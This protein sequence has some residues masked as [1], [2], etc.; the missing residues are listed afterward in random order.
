MRRSGDTSPRSGVMTSTDG[1]SRGGCANAFAYVSLPRKYKPL[2]KLKTSPMEEPPARSSSA[3]GNA[4]A[5]RKRSCARRPDV[6]AGDSKK[7]LRIPRPLP[8]PFSNATVTLAVMAQNSSF[9]VTTGADLQ[10]VDNAVNQASKEIQQ[11]YDF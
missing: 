7:T 2:R 3:S 6:L 10:E 9:D 5:S 1:T 4:A 8:L 11:R